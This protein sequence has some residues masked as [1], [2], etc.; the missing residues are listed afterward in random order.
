MSNAELDKDLCVLVV[1]DHPMTRNMVRAILRGVG[2]THV[3]TAENGAQGEQVLS[4]RHIDLIVCDWNMPGM[5]GLEFLN[6]VRANQT[7]KNLPFI[8]LTAEAYQENV[9]AAISAGVSDY[10]IKPFTA[11]ALLAKISEALSR[12]K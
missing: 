12:R 11:E 10:I 4:E 7:H 1:D 2:F 3:H 9:R 8:M 5:T 6:R